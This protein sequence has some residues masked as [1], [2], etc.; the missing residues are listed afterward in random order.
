LSSARYYAWVHADSACKLD[1]RP[2][3]PRSKVQRLTY[4]EVEA[5]GDMVQSPAH[6]HMSIRGLA[7]HAQRIGR[8]FA[9]PGTWSKLIRERGWRRPRLR[10]YPPKPK[11]GLRATAAN[12]V[13]HIDVSVIN[14]LDGTKAYV[15]AVIDNFSRRILAWAVAGRLDPM[16][17]HTV[18][19]QA[20]RNLIAPQVP[21]SSWTRASKISTARSMSSSTP[22]R[23]DAS[24]HRST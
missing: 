13:W 6:R 4:A 18:L 2:S 19:M 22:Q 21:T 15:H 10:L 12:E 23:C 5:I 1:D 17:T 7:L 20:A 24:S 3:C 11:L 9:H 16:N 8:V 14:L